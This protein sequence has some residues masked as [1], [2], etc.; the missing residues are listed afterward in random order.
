MDFTN[1]FKVPAFEIKARTLNIQKQLQQ[2]DIDLREIEQLYRELEHQAERVR[3]QSRW[4]Q[5][6]S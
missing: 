1:Q 3:E 4:N 2:T 6:A 5:E